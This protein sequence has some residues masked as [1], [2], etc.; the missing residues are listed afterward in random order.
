MSR[1]TVGIRIRTDRGA[2]AAVCVERDPALGPAPVHLLATLRAIAPAFRA[3]VTA[4][5]SATAARSNVARML[6]SLTDAA[7]LFD[8]A[9]SLVHANPAALQLTSSADAARLRG[10]AQRIA[11]GLGAIAHRRAKAGR[12]PGRASNDTSRETP[13]SNRVQVG[14]TVYQCRG[15]IVGEQLAGGEP[16]V[17]VTITAAA[18]KPLTDDELHSEYGLTARETQ[19]ARLMAEGLSNTEIAERLGVRFFTARN[20]VERTLAKLDVA[21]RQRVGPLLRNEPAEQGARGRASAA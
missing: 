14:A 15:T 12:G 3:G 1:N 4:W 9:G 2:V 20:H 8:A 19:V 10:E 6:D 7:L 17:L 21:N 13:P 11:W 16:A 5:I 18:A